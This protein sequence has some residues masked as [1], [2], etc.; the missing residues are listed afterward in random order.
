VLLVL[1]LSCAVLAQWGGGGGRRWRQRGGMSQD[2]ADVVAPTPAERNGVP[3][4]DVDPHFKSDVFTFIRIRYHSRW[5]Q[6]S[7]YIDAP[8]SDLNFSFRLQQMT[9]LKVDPRGRI[10]D[11]TDPELFNYPFIYMLEIGDLEFTDEEVACLRRYLLNGGFLMVDDH[12][13]DEEYG[14]FYEQFKRVFPNK[15]PVDLPIEHPIF[16]CVFDLKQKPQIPGIDW[17]RRRRFTG[18]TATWERDGD[19]STHEVHYRAWYD[20]KGRMMAI[21]CTNT[22]LGDGWEREGEEEWYFH[23]FSE[24]RAYPMGINIIFYAMTH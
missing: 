10:L 14:N 15:E 7:W 1:C 2:G 4:W 20:D 12:W 17:A 23:Q 5:R 16:H 3:E 19:P 9:S 22:D 24:K 8:D 18:S 13:G 6:G 21:T 11:L